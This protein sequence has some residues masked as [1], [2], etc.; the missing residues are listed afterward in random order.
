MEEE[1]KSLNAE[2]VVQYANDD[3][4]KQGNQVE[5]LLSQ[6]ID[7]LV[8]VPVN[9]KTGPFVQKAKDAGVPVIAYDALPQNAD[10]D[11]FVTRDNYKV[12][13]L[14]ANAALKYIGDQGGNIAILKGDPASTVAQGIATAY[15]KILKNNPKVHIVAEQ[16][17]ENWSTEKG[18]KTAENALSAQNDNIKA[19]VS[20]SD[21]LA[22]GVAQAVKGRNLQGKVFISGLDVE[23]GSARLIAEGVQSM[24][25]WTKIDEAAKDTIDAAVKLAKG[26]KPESESVT[27]NG[28]NDVPTKLVDVVAVDKD[29]LCQ[30]ITEI[31]PPGWMSAE[32][33][34]Q[35]GSIPAACEA[36]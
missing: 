27:N 1:A 9:D 2:L 19:F 22:M 11:L 23:L 20:S 36:K 13:E 32:Q 25:V 6:G 14:Q 4:T 29:N 24:S 30:F 33:V 34:Y 5:N 3:V 10:V 28:K 17:H 26:E 21:G 31:A 18:L 8:I 7:V 12:G 35:N 16:W 15:D